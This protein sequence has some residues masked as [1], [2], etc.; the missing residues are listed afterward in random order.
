MR[1]IGIKQLKNRLSEYVK[2]AAGGETILVTDCDRVVAELTPP[3]AG[4]NP[5]VVKERYAEA[6]RKGIITPAKVVSTEV[7]RSAGT[8]TFDEVMRLLDES[9]GDH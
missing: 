3:S 9:R 2:L 7:P 8:A 1:A 4:R 5:R 6:V